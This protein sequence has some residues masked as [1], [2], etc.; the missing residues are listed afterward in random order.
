MSEKVKK[1]LK[2]AR[3][4]LDFG[5]GGVPTLQWHKSVTPLHFRNYILEGTYLRNQI[6][7][8]MIKVDVHLW[9]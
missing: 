4:F 1:P 5:G 7:D 6:K 8:K 9:A 2:S 3:H